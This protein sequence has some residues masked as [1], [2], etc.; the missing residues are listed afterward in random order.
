[1][2]AAAEEKTAEPG[3]TI[4]FE[5]YESLLEEADMTDDQKREHVQAII[6]FM[7]QVAAFYWGLHPASFTNASCGKDREK[8][9]KA[10]LTA[11]SE[12]NCSKGNLVEQFISGGDEADQNRHRV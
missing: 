12:V 9:S 5:K 3:I 2:K 11:P 4:D 8:P 7:M 1:M 6:A 10:T